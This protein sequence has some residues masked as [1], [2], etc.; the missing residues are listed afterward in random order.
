MDARTSRGLGREAGLGL[1]D[2]DGGGGGGDGGGM[3]GS[4]SSAWDIAYRAHKSVQTQDVKAHIDDE[5]LKHAPENG[6]IPSSASGIKLSPNHAKTP[7]NSATRPFTNETNRSDLFDKA[8]DRVKST[9]IDSNSFPPSENIPN[10]IHNP[11]L[12]EK[13]NAVVVNSKNPPGDS[14][15]NNFMSKNY[16][17]NSESR[18]EVVSLNTQQPRESVDANVFTFKDEPL[19]NCEDLARVNSREPLGS[20][21][22]KRVER[23]RLADGRLAALKSV[24]VGGNDVVTC[25]GL[26]VAERDCIRL[27]NYKLLKEI[28]LM[29]QLQ[30]P[31]H[32]QGKIEK[33]NIYIYNG[34]LCDK[35]IAI[36][37][38]S[39][40]PP[41]S[42]CLP[43]SHSPPHPPHK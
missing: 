11:S 29:Q 35:V 39:P 40:D 24:W 6:L 34:K 15:K 26:G 25:A 41:P 21:Y 33:R 3:W 32:H 18:T 9:N 37:C 20:G 1:Y 31:E 14:L 19:L 17:S 38:P 5:N 13:P 12:N 16:R 23:A 22:T 4:N 7:E 42:H 36:K 27:A 2:D 43:L 30:H 10:S 8:L 28:A